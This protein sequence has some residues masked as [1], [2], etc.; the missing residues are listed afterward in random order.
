MTRVSRSAHLWALRFSTLTLCFVLVLAG[1][2]L[3]ANVKGKQTNNQDGP[4]TK[5]APGPNLPNL[6]EARAAGASDEKQPDVKLPAPVA[7]TRCRHQDKKCKETKEKRTSLI[8]A[9]DRFSNLWAYQRTSEQIFGWRA[10]ADNDLFQA[11]NLVPHTYSDAA[12]MVLPSALYERDAST[13]PTAFEN[14]DKR[15]SRAAASSFSPAVQ[16]VS[17]ETALADEINR[18]GGA[19]EDLYSG[20]YHWSTPIVSL[21]GRAGLDL[22]LTLCYNSLV[23]VKS[24]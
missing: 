18:M 11:L 24:L 14:P 8:P 13:V 7:A 5:G 19:S 22:N 12:P 23:W 2:P 10:T 17:F 6:D 1:I 3:D 4:R 20:N 21:P 9:Y 16:Q 15:S